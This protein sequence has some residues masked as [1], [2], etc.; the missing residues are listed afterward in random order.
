MTTLPPTTRQVGPYIIHRELGRGGM[1]VVYLARDTRLAR[2]V[3]IKSLPET[4]AA[5]PERLARFEREATVLASLNHPHIAQ[6]FD[7]QDEGG[8]RYLILEYV[9]GDGLNDRI[10]RG[11]LELSE[12]LRICSQI[13]RGVEAA[14]NR[15]IV[16]RDLKPDNVRLTEDGHVKVLDFGIAVAASLEYRAPATADAVT[17]VGAAPDVG[18]EWGKIVGTPGYMS[19][20]QA[21]GV[22][23]DKR[24]DVF[25]FGCIL[26]EM[27]TGKLAFPGETVNDR[28]AAVLRSEPDFNRLPDQTPDN[29]RDLLERCLVKDPAAR[30][31]D[32]GDASLELDGASGKKSGRTRTSVQRQVG[33]LPP[34]SSTFIGRTAQID[35]LKTLLPT[36][37]LVTLSGPGG[38]GKT[39][40]SVRV[41]RE[42]TSVHGDG[43][44]LAELAPVNDPIAVQ[45][46][47]AA[48]IGIPAVNG[49]VPSL[50]DIVTKLAPMD[51]M[52]IIDNCEHVLQY[53][54]R[55]VDTLLRSCPNVRILAT[56][57]EPLGLPG[58]MVFRVPTLSLPPKLE[59]PAD[60]DDIT[61]SE[62]VL[63]FVERATLA[64]P[65]FALT[66][67][68]APVI[69]KICWRLDGIPLA[70][71]FAAARVK[72]LSVDQI[73]DKL[74]QRFRLLTTN[75]SMVVERHQTL[76]ATVEWSYGLLSDDERTVLG[77]WS[78]F[79]GGWT[80]E[81]ATAILG[82]MMD[83]FEVLDV[84]SRL[85]D[86]SL[87][88]TQE[89]GD[90]LIRYGLLETVKQFAGDKLE[91]S[92]KAREV[93]D[94]H[95]AIYLDLARRSRDECTP[96]SEGL[97]LERLR[98]E[99]E[100]LIAA[101]NHL[102]RHGSDPMAPM[103]ISGAL[104]RL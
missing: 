79:A 61:Q 86:K 28:V 49:V 81:A 12:S 60:V 101:L 2:E 73:L 88:T 54:A 94:R 18:V 58:E 76:R 87:V 23:L 59:G 22:P 89:D 104:R 56:S 35:R 91:E 21:R 66:P 84:L 75:N 92:G 47:I 27:L 102:E 4:L 82:S 93:R 80:L 90:T 98:A 37:R 46:A 41:G 17:I 36:L 67:A 85:V 51:A 6:I 39:R 19:P 10:A 63:L 14:H 43:V 8:I 34:D 53:A 25:S 33:N 13:A 65:G 55:T 100:N 20:E 1:G 40:L 97:W 70:I 52:L 64:K 26:Y 31:R 48:A 78:A 69:A 95:A 30:L 57:R 50:N 15:G 103:A 96:A 42:F 83:E 29:V 99:R 74:D 3:A 71:E 72:V 45:G 7:I 32:L 62:S 24:S 9:A 38:C 44:W 11:S 16:H 77:V 5:D 68:N